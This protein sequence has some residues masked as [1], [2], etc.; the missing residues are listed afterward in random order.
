MKFRCTSLDLDSD[1]QKNNDMGEL[2]SVFF[3]GRK[4]QVYSKDSKI[5]LC[6]Q[7]DGETTSLPKNRRA[8]IHKHSA[9]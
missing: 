4:T 2:S 8:P 5:Q 9:K 3:L 1:K 6:C 7:N